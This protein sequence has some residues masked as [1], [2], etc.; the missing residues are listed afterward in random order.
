MK[1]M[2]L[3]LTLI[4]TQAMAAFKVCT[5]DNSSAPMMT[6]EADATT[7][8]VTLSGTQTEF[9]FLSQLMN[10]NGDLVAQKYFNPAYRSNYQ[11]VVV[12]IQLF[13]EGT[14]GTVYYKQLGTRGYDTTTYS[15]Q[16]YVY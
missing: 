12:E 11:Q 6:L 10:D 13:E 3:V 5:P 4:S 9:K 7:A 16:D 14:T 2:I 1:A 8:V 15:C